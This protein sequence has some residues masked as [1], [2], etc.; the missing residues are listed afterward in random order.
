MLSSLGIETQPSR[1]WCVTSWRAHS[2][3]QR[4]STRRGDVVRIAG[5]W[6]HGSG[7]GS[8]ARTV[9][10]D[11]DG[12]VHVGGCPT[13]LIAIASNQTRAA[14]A[15]SSMCRSRISGLE[16]QAPP[17]VCQAMRCATSPGWKP[18]FL[19]AVSVSG[20]RA[21]SGSGVLLSFGNGGV[22]DRRRAA[23]RLR[24]RIVA[25]A[26]PVPFGEAAPAES[27]RDDPECRAPERPYRRNSPAW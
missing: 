12:T 14:D 8:A 10:R 19:D 4:T 20:V 22:L 11:A 5:T 13:G 17:P 23:S 24:R 9:L 3:H 18:H 26:G 16:R 15:S 7:A 25:A 1:T 27:C 2:S 21:M 6:R